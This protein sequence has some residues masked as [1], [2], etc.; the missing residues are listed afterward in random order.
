MILRL[1]KWAQAKFREHLKKL[2]HQGR[3]MPT[4]KDV[5]NFLNDRAD[6]ANHLFF[7]SPSTE[8][9]PPNSKRPNTNDQT[10]PL[11]FTTLTT[12]GAKKD[13]EGS[14]PEVSKDRK[15]GNCPMCGRSH[16]LYRCEMFKSKPVEE[17]AEFVKKK[18]I[19]FNCINSVEHSSRSCK[20]SVCCRAPECGKPHHT[21]LHLPRPS[22][23][24]NV[25]HQANN[26]ETMVIP[27]VPMAPPDGQNATSSTCA[28]ATT[29]ESSEI[30]LQIIP[31]KVIGNN[32]RSITTYG[33]VDS[34]SDVTMIDP[35][36]I[37]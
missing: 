32:G 15:T 29:A 28:T 13:S 2:E 4:F 18:W 24:R 25:V 7:S 3:I 10:S 22:P 19:C 16:P 12:E 37:E 31:L 27:T 11:K 14:N 30:L 23:E 36:L 1:P 33:L 34:G 8:A 26:V 20:S 6:V 9:K 35:S 17:R 21:L 5:V